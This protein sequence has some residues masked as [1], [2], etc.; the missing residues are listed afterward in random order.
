MTA[1]DASWPSIREE[2]SRS[3]E[4][5]RQ[6]RENRRVGSETQD[7]P[8]DGLTDGNLNLGHL[9]R[10]VAAQTGQEDYAQL[11]TNDRRR[12][13]VG[14]G[15]AVEKGGPTDVPFA[16]GE[17]QLLNELAA[18]LGRHLQAEVQHKVRQKDSGLALMERIGGN[19]EVGNG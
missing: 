4:A 19:D 7:G 14:R 3:C 11:G 8:Q 2:T 17:D 5:G 6:Q 9:V 15:T 1:S 13:L 18:L 10:D 16:R 12:S